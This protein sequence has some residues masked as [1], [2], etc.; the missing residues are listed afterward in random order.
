MSSSRWRAIRGT[1]PHRTALDHVSRPRLH[2][3]K[4]KHSLQVNGRRAIP[5]GFDQFEEIRYLAEPFIFVSG[6]KDETDG[7][8]FGGLERLAAMYSYIPGN[9]GQGV[10]YSGYFSS[11]S[12]E[13]RIEMG[14]GRADVIFEADK[15]WKDNPKSFARFS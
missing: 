2:E 4:Q 7:K 8:L 1:A 15:S 10:Q 5:D 9:G 13:K 3:Q 12:R 14:D 6:A 11:F